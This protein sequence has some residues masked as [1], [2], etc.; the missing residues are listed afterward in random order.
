MIK[1]A[2]TNACEQ[3]VTSCFL[4]KKPNK[5][6][7]KKDWLPPWRENGQAVDDQQE[8]DSDGRM[9]NIIVRTAERM[10]DALQEPG[11]SEGA[12]SP[13]DDSWTDFPV[14]LSLQ[15]KYECVRN[16]L[17]ALKDMVVRKRSKVTRVTSG[18]H[19]DIDYLGSVLTECH[20]FCERY[21]GGEMPE[22]STFERYMNERYNLLCISSN[23]EEGLQ[24]AHQIS[25]EAKRAA[26]EKGL[27]KLNCQELHSLW[28]LSLQLEWE[29][30]AEPSPSQEGSSRNRG[31]RLTLADKQAW[32]SSLER[33][34]EKVA[35]QLRRKGS[36]PGSIRSLECPFEMGTVT[37]KEANGS[38]ALEKG[39]KGTKAEEGAVN[40]DIASSGH[41]GRTGSGVGKAHKD[42]A[43]SNQRPDG[44][45]A[46][47]CDVSTH[48]D[49]ACE[50]AVKD[51]HPG[52]PGEGAADEKMETGEAMSPSL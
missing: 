37:T 46:M 2:K 33:A 12:G 50:D 6:E 24:R 34:Q 41:V 4:P 45:D 32:R 27:E 42:E 13:R 44:L 10:L 40:M 29:A 16:L 7:D 48:I 49:E 1:P 5:L 39:S 25:E 36:R 19:F 15:E 20:N 38:E 22:Y 21:E 18:I 52:A 8:E 43:M 17:P 3:L 31:G 35:S 30:H 26:A 23:G 14:R 9:E 28:L 51:K 47:E 11:R